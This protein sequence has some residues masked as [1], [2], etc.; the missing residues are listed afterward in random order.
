MTPF[1][2]LP[3]LFIYVLCPIFLLYIGLWWIMGASI[4]GKINPIK[5]IKEL[6]V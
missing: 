6:K 1:F 3:S 5:I 4:T 2:S